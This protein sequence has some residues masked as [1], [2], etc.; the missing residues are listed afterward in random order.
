MKLLALIFV[1]LCPPAW[2]TALLQITAG[3][4]Q[5]NHVA[6]ST[7][8]SGDVIVLFCHRDGSTTAPTLP[9]GYNRITNSGGNTNSARIGYKIADGT[10]TDTGT[11]TNATSVAFDIL[12]G[13]TNGPIGARAPGGASSNSMSYSALTMLRADGTSWVIG[14]GAHCSATDVGTNVPSG[15]TPRSSATDVAVFDTNG[16]VSSWSAQTAGVNATFGWRTYTVEILAPCGASGWC[17][18]DLVDMNTGTA[19]DALN[20]ATNLPAGT[21]GADSAVWDWP[22]THAHMVIGASQTNCP[23]PKGVTVSGTTYGP[24]NTGKSIEWNGTTLEEARFGTV[25]PASNWVTVLACVVQ[26]QPDAGG[27]WGTYDSIVIEGENGDY[28]VAQYISGTG[29]SATCTGPHFQLETPVQNLPDV[30]NITPSHAYWVALAADFAGGRGYMNVYDGATG[31]LLSGGSISDTITPINP[32]TL[33]NDIRWGNNE[34]GTVC[35]T[36]IQNIIVDYTTHQ[37]PITFTLGSNRRRVWS[38]WR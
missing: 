29:A 1:L 14:F 23:L 31:S 11:C 24:N 19:G 20:A 26:T 9:S 27:A 22:D 35:C 4:A 33:Y 15:M 34:T 18:D 28:V 36:Y 17:A 38:N 12:R 7:H 10:E 32:P 8:A 30:C 3:S 37:W 2:A 25:T 6:I 5:A 16:A 13:Q 21:H